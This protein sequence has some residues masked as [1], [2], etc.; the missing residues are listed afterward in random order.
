MENDYFKYDRKSKVVPGKIY[1]W[2]ATIN[3]WKHL[4]QEESFKQV[5]LDSLAYLVSQKKLAV[6]A[7]VL[8]P[9]HIHLI[10][11][12]LGR[13]GKESVIGS[14]LKYTAHEFKKSLSHE[15]LREY[16]ISASN[17]S[18]EFWKRDSLAVELLNEEMA[19]QKLDYIH[20]NPCTKHWLLASDPINYYYSS[21]SY[22]EEGAKN[23]DFLSDLR[24]EF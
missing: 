17:K 20:N 8:M 2:T 22:Y 21:A 15:K 23:F 5:I 10:L 19:F 16:E 6:Y 7:F 11:K 4:L 13:N 14:F 12:A 24:Q 3:D 18:Y 9:N 1:F